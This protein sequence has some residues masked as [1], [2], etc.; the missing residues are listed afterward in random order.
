[1][2]RDKQSLVIPFRVWMA[3]IVVVL[4]Y[5]YQ[6]VLRVIPNVLLPYMQETFNVDGTVFGQFSGV[7][8]T[9]YALAHLPLGFLVSR[10]GLKK[11]LPWTVAI[12]ALGLWPIIYADT[13][14]ARLAG[15]V[16]TGIGS[17]FSPIA[18][19]YILGNFF[20]KEKFTK[21]FSIQMSIGLL[22]AIYAGAPL[23]H[24]MDVFGCK[25]V[26]DILMIIGVAFAAFAFM[27]LPQEEK[28]LEVGTST[29]GKILTN[30]KILL[31]GLAS[32]LM[33]G[34]LEGFP[35]AWGVKFL[36]SKYG[37][38][39]VDA[40][41]LTSLI[42]LGMFAGGPLCSW[43]A[44]YK[45][46]YFE[47]VAGV[48]FVMALCFSF[49]LLSSNL[50]YIL[51]GI[52]FIITGICCGFQVPALYAGSTFVAQKRAASMGATVVNMIMMSFGH[53]IHTIVGISIDNLGGLD[54]LEALSKGL[55]IIPVACVF[56]FSIFYL[57][58][59][60]TKVT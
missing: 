42:F 20:P 41:Q 37:L 56:G 14:T 51:L 54:S 50:P 35:D 34:T 60:T 3:W 16:L 58:A 12:S 4:F 18:G 15:R 8:Y 2:V 6:Y 28:N 7:Y 1:M 40:A 10:Y 26:I 21:L 49:M 52:V 47:T 55:S 30:P 33:V 9:G 43:M 39:T 25:T 13:W 31:I 46:R 38:D 45:N 17:S 57:L 59:K 29:V 23:A 24:L 5:A 48:G 53:I 27:I 22:A 19:F 44:S 11:I 32:G 36:S